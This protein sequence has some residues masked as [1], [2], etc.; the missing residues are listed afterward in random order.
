MCDNRR[1]SYRNVYEMD[2]KSNFEAIIDFFL[3]I[4]HYI[5]KERKNVINIK[6]RMLLISY[7]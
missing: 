3:I 5:K 6:E 1:Y 2:K 7:T 4:K